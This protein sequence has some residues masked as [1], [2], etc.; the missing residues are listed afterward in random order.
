M[1]NQIVFFQVEEQYKNAHAAIRADPSAKASVEKPKG[2]PK[3]YVMVYLVTFQPALT[4]F[5]FRYGRTRLSIQQR[6]DRVA[7]KKK[8]WL[9]KME[10]E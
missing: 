1:K 7:Q 2:K 9:R 5:F 6:K 10:E 8:A 3:R 4:L